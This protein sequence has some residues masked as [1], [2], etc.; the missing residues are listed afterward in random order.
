[1]TMQVNYNDLSPSQKRGVDLLST[2]D[3]A[4]R[5][6][7]LPLLL[8]GGPG[9]SVIPK[10]YWS[11]IRVE[12]TFAAGPPT[13]YALAAG[14]LM[15]AFGYKVGDS[16]KAAGFDT[17][18]PTATVATRAQ[19][20]LTVGGTQTEDNADCVIWGMGIAVAT[21]GIDADSKFQD[22]QAELAK[23]VF[24]STDVRDVALDANEILLGPHGL[25]PA[26][27]WPRRRGDFEHQAGL[28]EQRA[29]ANQSH[30]P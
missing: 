17:T 24:A 4:V 7:A 2:L 20:N 16:L 25:L 10:L 27:G 13:V 3:P 8:Q 11:T 18:V 5:E 23:A 12:T 28:H 6:M 30:A 29:R 9:Y 14:K 1:M 21:G 26:T 22:Q 19:T 15:T